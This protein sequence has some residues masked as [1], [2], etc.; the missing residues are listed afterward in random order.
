LSA[1][2]QNAASRRWI[3]TIAVYVLVLQAVFAGLASGAHAGGMSLDRTLAM[4]LC[5]PG[6][7]PAGGSS[8][9]GAAAH[10]QMTCCI[11]GCAFPGGA[12]PLPTGGYLPVTHRAVDLVA[13]ARR[14]DA[15]SGYVAG[16]SPANPRA[17]PSKA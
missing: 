6:E 14:L 12:A 8:D 1:F 3:A 4:T 2:R 15:P 9:N 11:L 16:R 7:M 10:D 5:A 13:F 17:P